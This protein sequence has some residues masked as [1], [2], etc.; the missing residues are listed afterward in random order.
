MSEIAPNTRI[1]GGKNFMLGGSTDLTELT[2]GIFA[3]D[4]SGIVAAR[5]PAWARG[6][7]YPPQEL[8]LIA[9]W[10]KKIKAI[11]RGVLKEDIRNIAGT[12]S[13]LL[14]FFERLFALDPNRE[15]LLH[16]Y[17]PN[18]E[19]ITHG[20]VNFAPY[21]PQ[22]EA[23]LKGS[24]AETREVYAASEG[25]IAAADRGPG[26]GMR[27]VADNQLFF[28]FIPLE[29]LDSKNPT[30]HWVKTIELGVDYA[31]AVTSCA[32]LFAYILGDTVK[33]VD[34]TPP[35]LLV[36]GRTSYYLSSFGEHLTG[37]DIEEAVGAATA[38]IG[39][40]SRT[41]PS[42]RF[43]PIRR[44]AAAGTSTSSSSARLL[45]TRRRASGF[46]RRSTPSCPTATTTTAPTARAVSVWTRR[47]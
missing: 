23:L 43:F 26:E 10:E 31:I 8:A 17:F 5:L 14:I 29:E 19:L 35:R 41:T 46:L 22:F 4:L 12:P 11:S 27:L 40:R 7:I 25:F 30:R 9:D 15:P 6:Y 2:E 34:R 28:E 21:R 20:G 24:H 47:S 33:F 38:A 36:T 44:T 3:G 1:L 32:G 16:A 18:L 13:W 45:P 39:R 42:A 37:E